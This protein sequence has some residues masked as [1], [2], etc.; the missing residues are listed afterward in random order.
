MD[1]LK[2]V[3]TSLERRL[4]KLEDGELCIAKLNTDGDIYETGCGVEVYDVHAWREFKY[5]PLCGK[6]LVTSRDRGT[7]D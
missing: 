6:K 2:A 7:S 1:E 3:L 4:R 5:C